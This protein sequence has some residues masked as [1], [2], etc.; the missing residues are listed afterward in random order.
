MSTLPDPPA[1]KRFSIISSLIAA[2]LLIAVVGVAAYLRLV[3]LDWDEGFHLHPDERF[4]ALVESAIQ[5][6][7]SLR[8]YFDTTT[9]TLNPNNVGYGFFVYGTFPV[10]LVRYVAEWV[11]K[12][13][14]YEVYLVGRVLSAAADLLT[15][16]VLFLIGR[17]LFGLRVGL[18]AA[19]LYGAAA[20][21]IQQSHFFTVDTFTNLFAVA[22]F[23]FAVRA[24]LKHN[25]LDYPLFGLML[26]L[27]MASKISIF[28]LALILI[29]ALALRVRREWEATGIGADDEPE[30]ATPWRRRLTS[31]YA[32]RAVVGL[33]I[34]GLVTVITFRV[35]QP[36]AFLP[37]NS[38]PSVEELQFGSLMRLIGRV[39]DPIGMRPN[40]AWLSQMAEVRRQVSGYADIPPNHQWGHR[41]PL[42][43]PWINMVR[44]GM[45][46]PLGI[47]CWLAFAWA[48]WEIGRRHRGSE[49]LILPV[50]WTALFFTWQGI[51][52]VKTM[53]YFLPVYPFLILLAAWAL[54][55]LWDRVQALLAERGAPRWHWSALFSG[56]LAAVVV[57]SAY[58]WGF[59]VSRIYTRPVTRVA[60]SRWMLEHVPSDV[61]LEFSTPTGPRR[62]QLGLPNNWLP[63]GQ[64]TDDPT[65]PA[66][67]YTFLVNDIAQPYSFTMPFGGTLT[68]LRLNHVVDPEGRAGPETLRVQLATSPDGRVI[69]AEG[70]VTSDFEPADD[71]R[72]QSYEL[73]FGPVELNAGETY[74]LIL[75]PEG[76]PLVLSGATVATEG[77]WDD[78]VPLSIEPYNVWG[79]QYQ[80]Y[81]LQIHWEDTED[82]RARMQY[83]LDRADYL[84]ISSN[85]FYDAMRRNP[86]RYPLTIAYY[87]AL[88]SGELGFDLV[89]DFT[90]RP[91]LGPIEF[92]DDNAEEAWTVYD[93]PRV[94]IFRKAARYDPERTA[95]ILNAVDLDS[96]VRL[97]AKDAPG[98]VARLP[99]PKSV[100]HPEVAEGGAIT[101]SSGPADWTPERRDIYS[102]VQPLAVI[103]WWALIALIGWA[104]FPLLY[105]IFPGLPDRA[106]P[107]SRVF[108]LLIG[109]W[110]AWM[111]AS[112][113]LLPWGGWSGLLA[114]F[115]LAAASAAL[116]APRREAFTT[117]LRANRR[118]ILLVEG[119]LGA[120]FLFFVLVR[121]G[122]PDLWHPAY[123]GEKPMDLAYFNAVLKSR[124]F[125]PYDPWFAGGTI[126]YY[127]FGFVLV[128]LPV[129]MLG[130]P[131]TLAYNLI[132][133]TLFA[134]TGGGA[135]SAAYNL[136]A[137]SEDDAPGGLEGEED[138]AADL[139]A[140]PTLGAVLRAW[141]HISP[142]DLAGV[143]HIGQG[144]A[145]GLTAYRQAV[146][147]GLGA[148]VLAVV[149]GNLDEIRTLLWGLAELG[150]G[151][152]AYPTRL[153]PGL[154]DVVRGLS[155]TL[156]DGQPLPV[157]LGE[158]Y[159]N[160]TR[161]IPVPISET[162]TPLEIG[163]ITEFPFFTFLYADL[164]AHMIAMP[165]TLAA[166]VWAIG[167]VRGA[168]H[169]ET[170][171][172]PALGLV[173][174]F[175]GAL[176][177]GALRP[178]NTW[179][180]PTYLLIGAGALALA[181]LYRRNDRAALPALGA[182]IAGA[183]LVG[184][185]AYFFLVS[186]GSAA[187]ESN[188]V[189]MVAAALALG[190][191]LAGYGLGLAIVR[192]R[193][194]EDG[195]LHEGVYSWV[196]LL[197]VLVRGGLLAA[198]TVVLYLPYI[199]NYEQGY[200]RFI[201]WEGSR[202]PLWAYLDILGLFLFLIASWLACETWAWLREA[203]E[204]GKRLR[205][206][207]LLPLFGGV[208]V[209]VGLV[210]LVVSRGYPVA[211]VALPG[212]VWALALFFRPGQSAE[213]RLALALLA[214]ALMLSLG[215]E[216]VVLQGDVGR[217]N[218]VFKF[219]LQVWL[220]LAIVAGAALSWLW[221]ALT[222]APAWL[223]T[224]WVSALAGLAFLAVLYP[225]VATRAKVADRWAP[226]APHTLDGMAY[227]RYAERYENGVV[228]SLRPD[229]LALRWLQD[230]IEG[231]PVV[232]EAQ[233]V[234]YHWGSRVSV[235]TGLPT[236]LGWN[237][238]QRQQRPDQSPEV[239]ERA[240][241]IVEMYNTP[242]VARTLEL[243]DRY[244]VE[245]IVVGDL[246]RAYYDPLGLE[247][248]RQMAEQGSLS[249]LYDRENTVIY[250]V[251]RG[252]GA[253]R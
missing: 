75:K 213:K 3:G 184:G 232:L 105:V 189:L 6:V 100:S 47:M 34:A 227:M 149:L 158:W 134:L 250:R 87:R 35:F 174:G 215:V 58:G 63:P 41:L 249:V 69:L 126:N 116:I 74:T 106:Y 4:L 127:Y 145:G 90:S 132:V 27:G 49:R 64:P 220:L 194:H 20:L 16:V 23:L 203:R 78:P 165:L 123:G 166:L 110:L 253:G 143:L 140:S 122:N 56:G 222:R 118:H 12:A 42:I 10:F 230:N 86:Q 162:G 119:L 68:T 153:L 1:Q 73:T 50:V 120:L 181:H 177:I 193:L 142:D 115:L 205:R 243:L 104:A 234:E 76:G 197:G 96:V 240:A 54:I 39:G 239:W 211:G 31:R 180:W 114:L 214:L 59:A 161:L 242:D 244:G 219:Y 154:S 183:A 124:A 129:G 79:A 121:V 196:T 92:Y 88:F 155:I 147:A 138:P 187:P 102:R 99:L 125:P 202:T 111:A 11:G 60:A 95:A 25:W 179:D 37:P 191:L 146:L 175:V 14:Y 17:R 209:A 206:A 46:W 164:H 7:D 141:P 190:G 188:A 247:K 62:Y 45:G 2:L 150:A 67:E 107:I 170:R 157:G 221:P 21:P 33:A 26:G 235:Y 112:L 28:P 178:T 8:A 109:A 246:E 89:A 72:G 15:L 159:W 208:I 77:A 13:S 29:L 40:P 97:I 185:G 172:P 198:G 48:L 228:F 163:P 93:H 24:M 55:T 53:R 81:E 251:V 65:R 9:S 207:H 43:F 18:L 225:L 216:V 98:P 136:V 210:A 212:S 200:T 248:F 85:R 237:W 130:M 36:Y 101:A 195:E 80:G 84:T 199:L 103:V 70:T 113:R 171:L 204:Q 218:T 52:W 128:G 131:V 236:V 137:R 182:G 151:V 156:R 160:A 169:S 139:P 201:P 223:R 30:P 144:R 22:S 148:T 32:V 19:A 173:N 71:P 82:K 167:Q 192:P 5:P 233:T 238:H 217:M 135:F 241:A 61:T 229:Y 66:V 168:A 117:W 133:P 226:E 108:G 186:A 91:N 231:R 152:A 83:I 252:Q 245:L 224:A 51:G 38:G 57:L 44:V 176:V 94:L